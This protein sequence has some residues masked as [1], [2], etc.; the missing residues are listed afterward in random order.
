VLFAPEHSPKARGSIRELRRASEMMLL[1]QKRRTPPKDLGVDLLILKEKRSRP[2]EKAPEEYI[3]ACQGGEPAR[4]Y[5]MDP[6]G[7]FRIGLADGK[8]AAW[9]KRAT[10]AGRNAAEVMNALI[11]LGLVSRLD[12]AGYLGRELQKA[13]LALSLGRSYVQDEP[14]LSNKS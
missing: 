5:V 6:A 1:A 10:V 12:H 9:H 8:I 11:D 3:E 13:E 14:L 4:G 7:C 2:A